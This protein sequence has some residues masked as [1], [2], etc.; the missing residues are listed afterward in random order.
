MQR[1]PGVLGHQV[2]WEEIDFPPTRAARLRFDPQ[3]V[4]YRSVLAALSALRLELMTNV[5]SQ[6]LDQLM[7]GCT[8]CLGVEL[9][10]LSSNNPPRHRVDVPSYHIST[11]AVRLDERCAS[12]HEGVRHPLPVELMRKEV[13][14]RQLLVHEFGEH[15]STKERTRATCKPFVDR[16]YWPVVLLDSLFTQSKGSNERDIKS[17]FYTHCS[18]LTLRRL[19]RI[20]FPPMHWK[21]A[22]YDHSPNPRG[23]A[24]DGESQR[25]HPPAGEDNAGGGRSR[26]RG[27]CGALS[28]AGYRPSSPWDPSRT[29]R[30]MS[31]PDFW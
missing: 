30:R 2:S 17:L 16:D 21:L 7:C 22:Y 11:E 1:M 24:M 26:V 8:V 3:K 31:V 28:L 18:V 4:L 27:W 6:V 29:R 5:P 23:M 19:P 12:A 14:L 13:A 15:Q 20:V 9:L 10:Q 25:S